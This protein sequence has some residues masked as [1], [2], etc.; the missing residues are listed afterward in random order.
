MAKYENEALGVAFELPDKITV[1]QQLRFRSAIAFSGESAVYERFW[2]GALQI[3]TEWTCER[4]PDAKA[5]DLDAE[6]D[7]ELVTLIEYVGDQVSLH[8]LELRS[9]PKNS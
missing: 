1:R 9:V 4:W 7:P 3:M 2:R 8:M 5:I 6:D